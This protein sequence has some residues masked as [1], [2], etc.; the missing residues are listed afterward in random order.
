MKS[1]TLWVSTLALVIISGSHFPSTSHHSIR[2]IVIDAGHGGQDSGAL[3]KFSKEKDITLQVARQVGK[4]IEQHMKPVKVIYT[5]HKDTF[6]AL[7]ERARIANKN[8]ADL[9]ISI[10]C[11]ADADRRGHGTETFTMG[12]HTA[13]SNLDLMKRENGVIRMEKQQAKHY[14]GFNPNAPESHIL[15]SLYQHAYNTNSLYLAQHIE[16]ALKTQLGRKSRGVK[17]A[18]FLVLWKTAAPSVLIEIGFITH[19]EEEKYLNQP[20]GQNQIA[21]A[22]F[23]GLK[24]YKQHVEQHGK[25]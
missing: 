9:F 23:E 12:L 8:K 22:I 14:A 2:K 10:H 24:Q 11:N 15:F 17:Q 16:S 7:H 5:R 25:Q 21:R 18:G 20:A 19:P 3:G 4:L 13:P 6:V 1:C